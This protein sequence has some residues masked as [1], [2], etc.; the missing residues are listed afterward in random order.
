MRKQTMLWIL[1]MLLASVALGEAQQI[2][3]GTALPVML[4]HTLDARHAKPGEKISGRIM[5]DVPL[6]D[7]AKIAERSK[8]TGHIVKAEPGTPSRLQLT[9]DSVKV[10]GRELA[11][12]THLRALASLNEV[13]EAR[14]P[15]NGIDDYDTSQSDWN[16]IQIG[17]AG[18]FRGN[19]EVVQDGHVV[20]SATDY[21][22]VTARFMA[23]PHEG[24]RASD[25][26]QALWLFSPSACGVYGF[27]DLQIVRGRDETRGV[28]ELQSTGNVHVEGGS[29]WLLRT[30][31]QG[32][33]RQ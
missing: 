26:Q 14:M 25:R 5:Q 7:G 32:S 1:S 24:C 8:V 31:E 16:T 11:V 23:A 22:A 33:T 28:I 20:G 9:F 3:P 21:G 27:S 30:N 19:G 17:G 2:P 4:D 6:P 18:V 10:D 15:T 12:S 13:F 29:G